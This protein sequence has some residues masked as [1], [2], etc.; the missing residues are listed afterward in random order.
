MNIR[1][2]IILLAVFGFNCCHADEV[3]LKV[4]FADNQFY[5]PNG[6]N[7][8]ETDLEF[9][10]STL[11]YTRQDSS[12][13]AEIE[14]KQT[15][16]K[17]D[18]ALITDHYLLNSPAIIDSVFGNFH[19]IRRYAL[20]PGTYSYHLSIKDIHSKNDPL[21]FSKTIS[22]KDFS[23]QLEFS[24]ILAAASI[25]P[26]PKKPNMYT[27]MGYD[28]IPKHGNYYPTEAQNLLYYTELYNAA[29]TLKNDS[30]YVVQQQLIDDNGKLDLSDYTRY[31][32]YKKSPLQ[33]IPK[34]IDIS[35]LP[36]GNYTLKLT[37]INRNK[38]VL[39]SKSYQFDRTN[40]AARH[41]VDFSNIV[42]DP[43]FVASIPKDST[44]YYVASLI[45]ISRQAE[46]K[47][48]IRILKMKDSAMNIKYLQAFW[49]NISP[50]NP[51]ESWIK[52]KK[53][54][55]LVGRLYGNNFMTG[56]ET[57]RGR[58][59]LEYGAPSSIIQR[60]S[61]PSEYP[62]EIWYYDRIKQY[63]KRRFVFYSPTGLG[64]D[65]RL[66]HSDMVGELHNN[67][68]RY[69]LNKRNTSGGSGFD[70]PTG[71]TPNYFGQH[72]WE[73]YNTF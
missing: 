60:P 65:Y 61:S 9:V 35:L 51:Y 20:A 2:L 63:S 37:V 15:I 47:N 19:D 68:W 10:G 14:V 56:F 53:Q 29:K 44:G 17:G 21:V 62:Y 11:I 3:N 7:Y 48:I 46:V 73:D 57:D 69:I 18:S 12:I 40:T 58:V 24:P 30:V 70:D 26:N 59:Y 41:K 22:I 1:I 42:I 54:V 4:Y 45:P 50:L 72:A 16:F 39:A 55:D 66:L 33:P 34:L 49:K 13:I 38:D 43:A 32:R 28:I 25:I 52:Y 36:S 8:L 71:G 5:T 67:R 23:N 27:R 6:G 31:F 64:T